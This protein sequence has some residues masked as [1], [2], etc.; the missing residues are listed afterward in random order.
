MTIHKTPVGVRLA[1]ALA[2]GIA[3][4]PAT[5][6]ETTW[7]GSNRDTW[8]CLCNWD[9]RLPQSGDLAVIDNDTTAWLRYNDG[10][11]A[12]V[13]TVWIGV[14]NGVGYRSDQTPTFGP[15]TTALSRSRSNRVTPAR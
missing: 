15:Q 10:R 14:D 3:A 13:Q 2:L 1:T 9:P 12:D 8:W 11:I 4:G 7:T 5:A 6:A